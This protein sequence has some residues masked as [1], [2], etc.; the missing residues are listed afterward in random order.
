MRRQESLWRLQPLQSM[1]RGRGHGILEMCHP[2]P[3]H[4]RCVQSL[5]REEDLRP[6]QSM[7]GQEK[8][9]RRLQSLRGEESLQPLQSMR[10]QEK[11]LRRLQSLQSMWRRRGG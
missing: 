1:R 7:R 8:G 11:G 9:L 5:C 6:L 10:C 3:G 4:G 2:A